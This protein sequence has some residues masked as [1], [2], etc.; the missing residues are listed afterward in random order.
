MECTRSPQ[1]KENQQ[2]RFSAEFSEPTNALAAKIAPHWYVRGMRPFAI[3]LLLPGPVVWNQHVSSEFGAP[4]S[5]LGQKSPGATEQLFPKLLQSAT[6]TLRDTIIDTGIEYGKMG[7]EHGAK[8]Y[9]GS[10]RKAVREGTG[11]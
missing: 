8:N 4:T 11:S 9:G 6:T 7:C 1:E 3:L 5:F 10:A 2:V